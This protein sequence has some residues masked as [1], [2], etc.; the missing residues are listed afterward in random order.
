[1]NEEP[2][3]YML[4]FASLSIVNGPHVVAG[5]MM[6]LGCQSTKAHPRASVILR[7]VGA[8]GGACHRGK[9]G[10]TLMGPHDEPNLA[11]LKQVG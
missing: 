11:F 10:Q 7:G 5:T 3:P 8:G 9:V 2:L 1:M 4:L 6:H